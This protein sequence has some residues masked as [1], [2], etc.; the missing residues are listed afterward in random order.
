MSYPKNLAKK[1]AELKNSFD[2]AIKEF[3]QIKRLVSLSDGKNQTLKELIALEQ[4]PTILKMLQTKL[5]TEQ[6]KNHQLRLEQEQKKSFLNTLN[7]SLNICLELK[8]EADAKDDLKAEMA[9]NNTL[10]TK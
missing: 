2:Q 9:K 4:D 3:E 5:K 1:T 10:E 6:Q 7:G 8:A